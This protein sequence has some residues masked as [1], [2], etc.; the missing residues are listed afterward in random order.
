[1]SPRLQPRPTSVTSPQLRSALFE[2]G[3][4]GAEYVL[5]GPD[6]RSQREKVSATGRAIDRSLRVEETSPD[7]ATASCWLSCLRSS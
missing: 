3:H 7:E 6:S 2:V 1:M 4:A 5:T